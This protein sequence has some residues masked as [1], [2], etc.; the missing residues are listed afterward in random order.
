MANIKIYADLTDASIHFDGSTVRPQ[1]LGSVEA[2]PVSGEPNRIKI[3]RK[4][5]LTINN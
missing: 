3:K 4:K 1:P 2:L 5:I